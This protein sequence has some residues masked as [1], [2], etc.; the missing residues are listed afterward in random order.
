VDGEVRQCFHVFKG[1]DANSLGAD[2]LGL[3]RGLVHGA[4]SVRVGAIFFVPNDVANRIWVAKANSLGE[5]IEADMV[6]VNNEAVH[7]GL[8]EVMGCYRINQT[9]RVWYLVFL[10]FVG[11]LLVVG[12]ILGFVGLSVNM[13]LSLGG[14]LLVLVV[15]M[16][17]LM[18]SCC[19][20]C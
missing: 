4:S 2:V 10:A 3:T 14:L 19:I 8:M 18:V 1:S 11:V 12:C 15:L 16:I 9:R 6:A 17:C 13:R 20:S 7:Y 5:V